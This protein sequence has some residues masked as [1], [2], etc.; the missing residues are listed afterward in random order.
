MGVRVW[1]T[2]RNFRPGRS[3]GRRGSK[4]RFAPRRRTPS[5]GLSSRLNWLRAAVLGA[6]DGIVSVAGIVLGVAG[7]PRCVVPY[8]PLGWRPG[9]RRG[10]DG[11]RRICV[12]RVSEAARSRCSPRERGELREMPAAELDEL[13]AIYEA[14]GVSSQT[15]AQVAAE[16]TA[17]DAMAAHVDAELRLD[18]DDLANPLQAAAALAASFTVGAPVP[19]PAIFVATSDVSA[20]HHLR[21]CADRVGAGGCAQRMYQREPRRPRRV[22]GG[23]RRPGPVSPTRAGPPLFAT[24]VNRRRDP[25]SQF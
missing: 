15:A 7:P 22:A 1:T 4:P 24:G 19:L 2:V 10:V 6:N 23:D 20:S 12:G 17:H 13:A 5:A 3:T 18:T 25:R 9:G 11:A 21:R 16:L 14:K 8:S